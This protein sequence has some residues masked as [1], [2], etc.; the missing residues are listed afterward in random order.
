MIDTGVR[1]L[2]KEELLDVVARS[3]E[4][5][6]NSI[7]TKVEALGQEIEIRR[8]AQQKLQQLNEELEQRIEERTAEVLRQKYILDTFMANVPDS[9]YFKDRES[10][11]TQA[12][13]S[14][15]AIFRVDDPADIAGKTDFDFFPEQ[16]ARLKYAQEQEIMCTGRALLNIEE[17]HADGNWALTTKM[18][19]QDEHGEI[20]GTFG[21]S[22]D[23]TTLKHAQHSLE[24]A[25]SE[26]SMLNKR[27]QKENSRMSA[28]LE[29]SR[30]IQ[31]MMLPSPQDLQ[32]IEGVDV[33]GFMQPADEVGGDYYDVLRQKESIHIGI[34]DV[35]GHGL[36][37]GLLMLM[38]QTAIRTLIEHGETDFVAC[39]S[40][41][42]Q[43]LYQ[44]IQR[45]NA[46]KSL[47]LAFVNYKKGVLKIVGQH[48]EVLVVRRNG[49]VER[50]D[51]ISL[52]FP[53][54]LME[55]IAE[56]V[57][58]A[59]I[60]LAPGDG[61]VLYTDGIT[62]AINAREE[63][64]GIEQL[65]C[66]ISQNWDKDAEGIKQAVV[67]DVV[68]HIGQQKIYDDLTLVVLKRNV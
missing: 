67:D 61:I 17:C 26:I 1:I 3:F 28:E 2:D 52:G 23:I 62:E 66:I 30:R 6:Q 15:A 50:I 20:I 18:P 34:G 16:E 5:M 56:F 9:I 68:R 29:I 25:Y 47:T 53:L 44:N 55:N 11:F 12:N 63:M 7:I 60:N 48:E 41:L 59:T 43:T 49:H 32:H 45:M 46:E 35:T 27:L 58:E 14:L 38:M 8:Q 37:S 65:C 36:E 31:Q 10:R 19:L 22:R 42:N 51:T 57:N 33:V 40:T 21:I 64:Y 39:L 13:N 54:G 24:Q 4:T